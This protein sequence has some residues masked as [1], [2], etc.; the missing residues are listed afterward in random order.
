MHEATNTAEVPDLP[1]TWQLEPSQHKDVKEEAVNT[2]QLECGH[3]FH[4][5]ALAFH[6]LVS[7]M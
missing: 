6:F 3:I 4:P 5:V 2:V 7:D 1:C